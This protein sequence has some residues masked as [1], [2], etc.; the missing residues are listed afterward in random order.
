MVAEDARAAARQLR[1]PGG[2]SRITSSA[3]SRWPRTTRSSAVSLL[4]MPL[5]PTISTPMPSTSISTPWSSVDGA[6]RSAIHVGDR[7]MKSAV[8]SDDTSSGTPRASAALDAA[9][10]AAS[11][12]RHTTTHAGSLASSVA[13]PS[14]RAG[15]SIRRGTRSRCRRARARDAACSCSGQPVSARP[16][17]WMRGTVTR[18]REPAPRR[19]TAVT[20][21]SAAFEQLADRDSRVRSSSTWRPRPLPRGTSSRRR[22]R[23]SAG[24]GTR[25]P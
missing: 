13:M 4:P 19:P 7:A 15:S 10:R 23:P 17:F 8:T 18:A 21:S 16:G 6:S 24:G 3:T 22:A 1:C 12:P 2:G 5:L 25:D 11:A 20:P 14:S 9:P